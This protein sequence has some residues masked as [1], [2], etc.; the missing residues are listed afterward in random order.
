MRWGG[1]GMIVGWHCLGGAVS[2]MASQQC[3]GVAARRRLLVDGV[4]PV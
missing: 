3:M 2:L 1:M 4:L